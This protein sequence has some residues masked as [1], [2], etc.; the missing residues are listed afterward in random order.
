MPDVKK[1]ITYADTTLEH[2]GT[3]Y[4]AS[5]FQFDK[6]CPPDYAYVNKEGYVMKKKTLYNLAGHMH[7]TEAEYAAK[8]GY[9]KVFG[10][11]KL[12]FVYSY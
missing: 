1:I 12:R 2:T 10:S 3:I 6:S 11:E 7:I 5:N 9:E 8:F 4:K